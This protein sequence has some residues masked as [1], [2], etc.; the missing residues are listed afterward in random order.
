M[1]HSYIQNEHGSRKNIK[2]YNSLNGAIKRNF[3]KN[4]RLEVQ[5]RMCNVLSKPAIM[6][7]S[8]TWVLRGSWGL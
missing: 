4:M 7:S 2:K 3:E 1:W 8:E 5:L 6:Y